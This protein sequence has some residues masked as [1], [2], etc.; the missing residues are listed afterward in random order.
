MGGRICIEPVESFLK[1][2][3]GM[4]DFGK[5]LFGGSRFIFWTLAP[6]L[7]LFAV[8]MPCLL[9]DWEPIKVTLTFTL[10]LTALLLALGLWNP[11]RFRWVLRSV[12]GIV[13]LIF[14]AYFIEEA[15]F[16]KDSFG[17]PGSRSESNPLNAFFGL[18][19]IGLP[20]LVY[21]IFGQFDF[22]QEVEE[23]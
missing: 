12:T 17:V 20:C 14:V 13:F 18:L 23:E 19:F 1:A 15:F 9:T 5:K 7:I 3:T 8:G 2:P 22:R 4:S 21:T 10:A 16:N 11:I 6:V